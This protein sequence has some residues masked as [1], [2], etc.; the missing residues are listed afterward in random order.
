MR[1]ATLILCMAHVH[2][3]RSPLI[4]MATR[5]IW[6]RSWRRCMRKSRKSTKQ[7]RSLP[8]FDSRDFGE[9]FDDKQ[10]DMGIFE[11][12]NV[13]S[14]Y[15]RHSRGSLWKFD[16]FH[17]LLW[18]CYRWPIYRWF[19]F[20]FL[21]NGPLLSPV[22]CTELFCRVDV[23]SNKHPDVSGVFC[24]FI[25]TPFILYN[26]WWCMYTNIQYF[27]FQDWL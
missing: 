20:C 15:I 13:I 3:T 23:T 11:N 16:N 27:L 18:L 6:R 25:S 9:D 1:Y 12:G 10:L 21:G 4:S 7:T 17:G 8:R 26:V 24:T 14:E 2:P 5:S 19:T 22:K